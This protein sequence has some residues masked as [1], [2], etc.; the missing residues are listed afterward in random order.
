M[1]E[2]RIAELEAQIARD[3][4]RFREVERLEEEL[5]NNIPTQGFRAASTEGH[6]RDE[7]G[8]LSSS[9]L[10][11]KEMLAGLRTQRDSW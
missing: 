7:K 9:I 1:D 4:Q 10:K 6:Y 2:R 3:E 11:A 8:A 5:L